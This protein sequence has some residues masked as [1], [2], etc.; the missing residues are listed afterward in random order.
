MDTNIEAAFAAI[1]ENDPSMLVD[2]E[3]PRLDSVV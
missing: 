3:A 2:Y 1:E